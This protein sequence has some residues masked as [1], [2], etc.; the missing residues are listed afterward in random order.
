MKT[1]YKTLTISLISS[2][3]LASLTGCSSM[4]SS[5]MPKGS[6]SMVQAYNSAINGTDNANGVDGNASLKQLRKNLQPLAQFTPNV[7][8][9]TRTQ[10]NEIQNQFPLLPNPNIV[11]YVYPHEAGRGTEKAPVPGYST[12]FP[13]YTHVHYA[14]PGDV[15]DLNK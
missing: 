14:M 15:I 10:E 7:S 11:M 12:V 8:T 1:H 4:L 6:V 5:K 13:L 9:Y 3:M 2:L